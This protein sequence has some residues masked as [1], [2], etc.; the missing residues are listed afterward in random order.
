MKKEVEK[1]VEQSSPLPKR[2]R[3]PSQ[4]EAPQGEAAGMKEGAATKIVN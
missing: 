2:P 4:K 3:G 1:E